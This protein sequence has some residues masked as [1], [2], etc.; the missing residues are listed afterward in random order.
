MSVADGSFLMLILLCVCSFLQ[1]DRSLIN[2]HL[3]HTSYFLFVMAMTLVCYALIRGKP[4]Q[5]QI[6]IEKV[7]VWSILQI[8]NFVKNELICTGTVQFSKF[9]LL[10][11]LAFLL[12]FPLELMEYLSPG[13]TSTKLLV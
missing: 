9:Y 12:N 5:K 10:L 6:S 7:S 2:L 13:N 3:M 4:K 1:R 8:Y 11:R